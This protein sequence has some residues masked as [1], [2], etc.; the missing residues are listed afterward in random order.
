MMNAKKPAKGLQCGLECFRGTCPVAGK[1]VGAGLT[2]QS[3]KL[4]VPFYSVFS[5]FNLGDIF[6]NSN[7]LVR[8]LS[9][10]QKWNDR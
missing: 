5:C 1:S 2:D 8:A 7:I 10:V 9:T 4:A 3:C 6:A